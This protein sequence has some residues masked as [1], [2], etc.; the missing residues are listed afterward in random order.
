MPELVLYGI[1]LLAK[2]FLGSILDIEVDQSE[3]IIT[4]VG[5]NLSGSILTTKYREMFDRSLH[6]IQH[7]ILAGR[8]SRETKLFSFMTQ[9]FQYYHFEKNFTLL[10]K[11]HP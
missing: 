7:H 6:I 2:Q 1:G 10:S 4:G 9:N 11:I 8:L 3:Q 5:A